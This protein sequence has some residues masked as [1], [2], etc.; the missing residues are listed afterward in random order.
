M[1]RKILI[2][3]ALLLV[4]IY[5]GV[6]SPLMPAAC[7]HLP[8]CSEYTIDALKMYG[9]IRGGML[10]ANRIARCRPWGTSGFDPVPRFLFKK[11]KLRKYSIYR[12]SQHPHSS[13]LKSHDQ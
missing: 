13:R 9:L 11:V 3:P 12:P 7:R 6:I 1:L 8:T 2:A 5:K 10:A 4:Y